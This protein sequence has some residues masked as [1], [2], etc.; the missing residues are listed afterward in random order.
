MRG[1]DEQQLDVEEG[2]GNGR[3]V[4]PSDSSGMDAFRLRRRFV[5]QRPYATAT[6]TGRISLLLDHGWDNGVSGRFSLWRIE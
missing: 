1:K 4:L 5:K 6:T 3:Q 2:F